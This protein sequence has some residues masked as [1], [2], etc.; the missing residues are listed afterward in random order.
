MRHHLGYCL[1][2]TTRVL[3][4]IVMRACKHVA[5]CMSF[6]WLTGCWALQQAAESMV[7]TQHPGM[8]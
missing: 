4:D 7:D 6:I 1:Q 8:S 5:F 3:C 2:G